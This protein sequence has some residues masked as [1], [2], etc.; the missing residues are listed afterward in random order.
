MNA[1]LMECI[2]PEEMYEHN[3]FRRYGLRGID[4]LSPVFMCQLEKITPVN[5]LNHSEHLYV[6]S[7]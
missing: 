2:L 3:G 5:C 1:C 7:Q 6:L 4:K